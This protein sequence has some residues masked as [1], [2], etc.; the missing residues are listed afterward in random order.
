MNILLVSSEF[1]P[2]KRAAG[3]GSYTH[4]LAV[5]IGKRGH[6]VVVLAASDNVLSSTTEQHAHF[7]LH[8]ISGGDFIVGRSLVARL[9]NRIRSWLLYNAFRKKVDRT[10]R[11]LVTNYD[12]DIVELPEYGNEG[13]YWLENKTVPTVMRF[14]CPSSLNMLNG[15]LEPR[16]QRQLEELHAF[17]HAD[18][19]SFVS[20]KMRNVVYSS[21]KYD[22]QTR[23]IETT[24]HN[25]VD[26]PSDLKVKL[27]PARFPFEIVGAGSIGAIKGWDRLIL[28]CALLNQQETKVALHLYGRMAD[29]EKFIA[30][31]MRENPRVSDWLHVHGP[32]DREDLMARYAAADL[33]CFPSWFE[34][35]G[36]TGFEAMSRGALVMA[37]RRGGMCELVCEGENGFLVDPG[38]ETSAFADKIAEILSLEDSEKLKVRRNAHLSI[39]RN[40]SYSGFI[41]QTLAFY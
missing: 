29:L 16:N 2:S 1:P 24:I 31:K 11:A 36:L 12:I 9:G 18:A 15:T 21:P 37:S 27:P 4:D 19:H 8:R 20:H 22:P 6:K 41:D 35:F 10:I 26:M 13:K 25:S 7:V 3:I 40:H 39:L 5:G 23:P 14:H 32:I 38:D 34:S 33:C 17:S 30:R 28:A